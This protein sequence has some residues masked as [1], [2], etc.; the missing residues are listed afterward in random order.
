MQVIKQF[1]NCTL[2]QEY[3][4][5]TGHEVY[6][7]MSKNNTVLATDSRIVRAL[8]FCEWFEEKKDVDWRLTHD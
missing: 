4:A 8:C 6:R 7:V 2:I 3:S 5:M 1:P